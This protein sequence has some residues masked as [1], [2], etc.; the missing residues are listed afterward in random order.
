VTSAIL[1]LRADPVTAGSAQFRPG[2]AFQSSQVMLSGFFHACGSS[3]S[4]GPVPPA[5]LP[6]AAAAGVATAAT[7]TVASAAAS[8]A[9]RV[10]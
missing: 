5:G 3:T 7:S 9:R 8:T 4:N 1:K 6:G 10:N 2:T